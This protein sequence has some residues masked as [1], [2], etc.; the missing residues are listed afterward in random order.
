MTITVGLIDSAVVS[1]NDPVLF[2]EPDLHNNHLLN[3][4]DTSLFNDPPFFNDLIYLLTLI[5]LMA[6][7]KL[8][9]L[10]YV[11]NRPDLFNDHGLLNLMA[12]SLS[13]ARCPDSFL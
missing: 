9:D 10:L 4:P 3:G 5:Y 11:Y 6:L 7:T 12:V 13:I 2:D 1:L 8:N